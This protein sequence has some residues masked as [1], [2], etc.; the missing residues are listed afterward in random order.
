[1]HT[2]YVLDQSD[3]ISSVGGAWDDFAKENGG[4]KAIADL[5][6]GR[7]VWDFINDD[8]TASMFRSVLFTFRT[9][10]E[11]LTLSSDCSNASVRR[12]MRMRV[13]RQGN[14]L[15]RIEHDMVLSESLLTG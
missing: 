5:V 11:S 12:T 10:G 13:R 7:S 6:I 4:D 3:R 8:H 14:D 2:W 9:T 1:M 15:L